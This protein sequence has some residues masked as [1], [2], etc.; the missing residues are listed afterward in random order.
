MKRYLEFA[1]VVKQQLDDAL[2][3]EEIMD[4][5][6]EVI[7]NTIEKGR[8]V[9]VFGCGHS[10]MF[11]EELCFR[12]GGLVPINAIMIPQYNIYPRARLSQLMERNEG[13]AYG[14]LDAMNTSSDD[15]MII[16]SVSGR[17]A[18]VVDMAQA[19][20]AKG[21]HVI[22]V[23]SYNYTNNVT[24]RHSS[25]LLLKDVADTVLDICGVYGDSV[26]E[27][28]RVSEKFCSTSTVVAMTLLNGIVGEVIQI[29]ADRGINPPIWVSGNVDRGDEI[30]G[31]HMKNYKGLVDII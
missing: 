22:G 31:E 19:A 3:Q 11:G 16:V 7:A 14:V 26:L 1:S 13:F 30:N 25:G 20:K 10:Q 4:K 24:S 12:T 2:K 28:E 27:D 23:T 15:T 29:L 6:A 18:A 17:N 9:H 8:V 5:C 21:M